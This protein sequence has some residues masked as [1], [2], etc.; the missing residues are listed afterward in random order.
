MSINILSAIAYVCYIY[1]DLPF[2]AL[3]I[4]FPLKSC[5]TAISQI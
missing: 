5:V 4:F 3:L 1:S 2:F